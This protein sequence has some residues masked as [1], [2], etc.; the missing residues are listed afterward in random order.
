MGQELPSRTH[1]TGIIR[2]R[3]LP[4]QFV[5]D[6]YILLLKDR[7]EQVPIIKRELTVSIPPGTPLHSGTPTRSPSKILSSIYNVGLASVRL[8]DARKMH[9]IN[10]SEWR[11]LPWF[12]PWWP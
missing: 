9:T 8:E 11:V 12:P 5:L 3:I 1:F 4:V 6:K 2:K 7:E 10:G